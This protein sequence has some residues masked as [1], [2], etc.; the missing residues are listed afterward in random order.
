MCHIEPSRL[1]TRLIVDSAALVLSRSLSL[2]L[3]SSPEIVSENVWWLADAD[4]HRCPGDAAHRSSAVSRQRLR[5]SRVREQPEPRR[6]SHE[7]AVG[8]C[9]AWVNTL[10]CL[11]RTLI[12]S[13]LRL[14]SSYYVGTNMNPAPVGSPLHYYDA[15][16]G[17]HHWITQGKWKLRLVSCRVPVLNG[18]LELALNQRDFNIGAVKHT[19]FEMFAGLNGSLDLQ[20]A[21]HSSSYGGAIVNRYSGSAPSTPTSPRSSGSS[22]ATTRLPPY[23]ATYGDYSAAAVAAA[24]AA[25]AGWANVPSSPSSFESTGE[26]HSNSIPKDIHSNFQLSIKQCL[27]RRPAGMDRAQDRPADVT[28]SNSSTP[29]PLR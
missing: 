8:S 2:S 4:R 18:I 7:L 13:S 28:T 11:P 19:E 15:P 21:Q 3:F 23:A 5:A 9:H 24:A 14:H 29:I 25:A 10:A 26:Q 22:A 27:Y 6:S 16:T 20:P 12:L 17:N 1:F